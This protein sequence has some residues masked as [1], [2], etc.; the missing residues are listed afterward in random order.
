MTRFLF[1]RWINKFLPLLGVFA[2][3]GG[4]YAGTLLLGLTDDLTLNPGYQPTQ[5]VPFSHKLHAG[6][7]KMDCRYCHVNV[8]KAANASIPPTATCIN[9]HSPLDASG[10]STALGAVHPTSEKLRAVRESFETDQSIPWL[11][12]HRLPDYVFFNHSAHVNRGV[13][14]VSCHGRIDTMEKVYQAE[15]LSMAWC[16]ECHR[17]P[18]E[19][20]RPVELI[21]K[22]DWEPEDGQTKAEI[23]QEL[24]DE[25]GIHPKINCAVCHR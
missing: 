8:E 23:G 10:A 20:I 24:I 12:I 11:R 6:E 1:P 13:S 9:C 14:C 15:E 25:L 17:D 18:A 3:A 16:I 21:T 5:P 7:L 4:G 22:L 19:H 2:L